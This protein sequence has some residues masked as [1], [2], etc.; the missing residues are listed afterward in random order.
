MPDDRAKQWAGRVAELA[1]TRGACNQFGLES[2]L[3]SEVALLFAQIPAPEPV[4]EAPKT[5]VRPTVR[6]HHKKR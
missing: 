2:L 1:V 3:A 5:K 6:D 4:V